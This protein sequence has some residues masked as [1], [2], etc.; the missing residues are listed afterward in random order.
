MPTHLCAQT[1]HSAAPGPKCG[2]SHHSF[3]YRIHIND[4][5]YI[6]IIL[7]VY[8]ICAHSPR[9]PNRISYIHMLLLTIANYKFMDSATR[10]GVLCVCTQHQTWVAQIDNIKCH[11]NWSSRSANGLAFPQFR[12][13]ESAISGTT[14]KWKLCIVHR[15]N[16]RQEQLFDMTFEDNSAPTA[17]ELISDITVISCAHKIYESSRK[18]MQKTVEMQKSPIRAYLFAWITAWNIYL[19]LTSIVNSE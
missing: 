19:F 4:V 3:Q 2:G 9:W 17:E 16:G 11:M 7:Y 1:V 14:P 6:Y 18:I 5:I 10:T 15:A 8:V 12:S 13:R